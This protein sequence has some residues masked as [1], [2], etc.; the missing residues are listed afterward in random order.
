M[1]RERGHEEKGLIKRTKKKLAIIGAVATLGVSA[2]VFRDDIDAVD[3]F[4]GL[5]DAKDYYASSW[6]GAPIGEKQ[7]GWPIAAWGKV[8]AEASQDNDIAVNASNGEDDVMV[9]VFQEGV[10]NEGQSPFPFSS[11]RG[12]PYAVMLTVSQGNPECV[13]PNTTGGLFPLPLLDT[14]KQPLGPRL[15]SELGIDD[16]NPKDPLTSAK[17]WMLYYN[18]QVASLY[19]FYPERKKLAADESPDDKTKQ[20]LMDGVSIYFD[21]LGFPPKPEELETVWKLTAAHDEKDYPP[22]K[23]MLQDDRNKGIVTNLNRAAEVI[24]GKAHLYP[25]VVPP[26]EIGN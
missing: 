4:T 23:T 12:L 18:K 19:Q 1:A 9:N 8:I 6:M 26:Q 22:F 20:L 3:R 24:E 7:L 17:V 15:A 11:A 10:L 21:S 16:Y 14:E 25:D 2:Y 5:F 13:I